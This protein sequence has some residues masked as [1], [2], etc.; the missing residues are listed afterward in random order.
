[1]TGSLNVEGLRPVIDTL[2]DGLTFVA[3]GN[4]QA[5]NLQREMMKGSWQDKYKDL[6]C[7]Q[8]SDLMSD[9]LFGD[10]LQEKLC[11]LELIQFCFEVNS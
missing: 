4:E 8:P 5:N 2:L 6:T 7:T 1:M 11:Y 3:Y 9:Q 10:N